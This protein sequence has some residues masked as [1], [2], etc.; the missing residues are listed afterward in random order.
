MDADV[1]SSGPVS[2]GVVATR[3]LDIEPGDPA[4]ARLVVLGDS[5]F[6]EQRILHAAG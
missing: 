5:E 6:A 3:N 1:R 2:L 4:V